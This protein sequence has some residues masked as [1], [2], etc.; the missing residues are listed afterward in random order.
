[1]HQ[2][3]FAFPNRHGGTNG[4][5]LARLGRLVIEGITLFH[6]NGGV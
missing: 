6:T 5:G 2:Q 4:S 1:M 3:R